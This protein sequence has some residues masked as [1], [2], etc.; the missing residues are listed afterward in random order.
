MQRLVPKQWCNVN[1]HDCTGD[2]ASIAVASGY[3]RLVPSGRTQRTRQ[4]N[5]FDNLMRQSCTMIT[6][7]QA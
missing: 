7:Q 6:W 5:R 4:E 2:P 1:R 3:G